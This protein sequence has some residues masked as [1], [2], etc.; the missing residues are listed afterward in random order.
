MSKRLFALIRASARR[1]VLAGWTLLSMS[2]CTRSSL[3]LRLAASSAL[4]GTLISKRVWA[5]ASSFLVSAWS[6]V[7]ASS[8]FLLCSLLL[9]ISFLVSSS[10][11]AGGPAI[12]VPLLGRVGGLGSFSVGIGTS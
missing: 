5:F 11:S 4:V 1:R 2:P 12:L 3:P 9:M 6:L 10:S 8:F 7:S